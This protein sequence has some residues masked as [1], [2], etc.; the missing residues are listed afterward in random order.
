MCALIVQII[1][2]PEKIGSS[3]AIHPP[4]SR[5][6]F[7]IFVYRNNRWELESDLS[8]P[9]YEPS[10]PTIP[11]SFEGQVVKKESWPRAGA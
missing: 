3:H 2:H 8:A 9:G 10:P 7:G 6:G 11:G 1:E 5:G 4:H